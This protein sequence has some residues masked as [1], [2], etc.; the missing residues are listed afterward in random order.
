VASGA[1][2]GRD[3]MIAVASPG[4]TAAFTMVLGGFDAGRA[5]AV[6]APGSFG[7]RAAVSADSDQSIAG[8]AAAGWPAAACRLGRKDAGAEAIAAFAGAGA[9][10]VA[11][12][13]FTARFAGSFPS[14]SAGVGEEDEAAGSATAGAAPAIASSTTHRIT[15]CRV[16]LL[17]ARVF[18]APW[19][20]RAS[21]R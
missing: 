11:S 3:G 6:A 4:A 13:A 18:V 8:K 9:D 15:D 21:P 10:R 2:F 20:R 1:S 17:I 5:A 16:S 7:E 12:G 19:D 14:G